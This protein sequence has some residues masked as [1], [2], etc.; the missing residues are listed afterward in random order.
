MV[1]DASFV[2]LEQNRDGRST[3]ILVDPCDSCPGWLPNLDSTRPSFGSQQWPKKDTPRRPL[4]PSVLRR[5]TPLGWRS[6]IFNLRRAS[7]ACV[8]SDGSTTEG[9]TGATQVAVRARSHQRGSFHSK[10]NSSPGW[11]SAADEGRFTGRGFHSK[12]SSK[13]RLCGASSERGRVPST[14]ERVLR[15]AN[16]WRRT[17]LAQPRRTRVG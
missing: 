12:N 5:R 15:D 9:L 11:R 17:E 16:A 1:V 13:S 4:E 2:F 7:C 14:R 10:S 3:E 8:V 6:V